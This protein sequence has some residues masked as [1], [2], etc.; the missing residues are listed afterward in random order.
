[1]ARIGCAMSQAAAPLL[2]RCGALGDMVL[3]TPLIHLLAARHGRPVELLTAGAWTRALL[4]HDSAIGHLQV[5]G[6]R[7]SPHW[8]SPGQQ[9]AVRWLRQRGR[10]P[11][12][13]CDTGADIRKLLARAGVR[14]EDTVDFLA[15]ESSLQA[16]SPNWPDAW[17]A[18]GMR[19]PQHGYPTRPVAD[20]AAFRIPT[21]TVTDAMR[22]DLAHWRV[23]HALHGPLVLLQPGNKRTHKRGKLATRQ[24]NKHWPPERWAAVA[25]H[26]LAALPDAHVVLCG[27]PNEYGVL[28]DVRL[29]AA[30]PRVRNAARELPVPRLL[31]LLQAAHSM[32]S[33]D[34]GPAHAAAALAC[35]LVVL[36]GAAPRAMW[37]PV[38]MAPMRILGG[39]RGAD[40]RVQDIP[41]Q[42]VIEAWDSLRAQS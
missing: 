4:Q 39:E 12:Y 32:I 28:E 41:A 1:M 31:A 9:R 24:H 13:L 21:L 5:L 36:F 2:V 18:L 37:E 34:T 33:V 14:S 29:A 27:S 19:D 7:K 8:L 16:A 6:S 3:L 20:P 22:A 42:A 38:G 17:V 40:S 26:A 35:P 23:R 30:H 11:V 10:G 25:A 15:L